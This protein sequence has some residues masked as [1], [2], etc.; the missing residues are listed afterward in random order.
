LDLPWS[1]QLLSAIQHSPN[2]IQNLQQA[3]ADLKGEQQRLSLKS[4]DLSSQL[5]ESKNQYA[6]FLC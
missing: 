5:Q 2:E 1:W 4:A 3:I 6:L